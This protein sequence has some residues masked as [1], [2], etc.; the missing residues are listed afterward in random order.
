MIRPGPQANQLDQD[1]MYNMLV[2]RQVW[3][4]HNCVSCGLT[5]WFRLCTSW[6]AYRI[7]N[8]SMRINFIKIDLL[9][10]TGESPND[11]KHTCMYFGLAY[12]KQRKRALISVSVILSFR[13]IP[14][15]ND[16][17]YQ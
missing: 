15:T 5:V 1:F 8:N 11:I 13:Q 10:Y 6:Y 17:L 9:G 14:I 4:D 2:R 7:N 16:R 3:A 12:T